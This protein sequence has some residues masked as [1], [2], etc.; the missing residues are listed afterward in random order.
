MNQAYAAH[1]SLGTVL[2]LILMSDCHVQNQEEHSQVRLSHHRLEATFHN[3]VLRYVSAHLHTH[4]DM[5]VCEDPAALL[6]VL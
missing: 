4:V 3:E 5:M 2:V 6:A 1:E